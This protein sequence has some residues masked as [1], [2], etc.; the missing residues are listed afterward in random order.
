M[1]HKIKLFRKISKIKLSVLSK[2]ILVFVSLV[3]LIVI[4]QLIFNLFLAKEIYKSYKEGEM[5][6]CFYEIKENYDGSIASITEVIASYEFTESL[7]VVVTNDTD[8]IYVSNDKR[9]ETKT[10]LSSADLGGVSPEEYMQVPLP[11]LQGAGEDMSVLRLLGTFIFEE[12][13]LFVNITMP[14]ASIESSVQIFTEFGLAISLFVLIL[15]CI[16]FVIFSKQVTRPI[17]EIEKI[18]SKFAKLDF[19]QKANEN[20]SSLELASLAKSINTMSNRLEKNIAE[21]N[22]AN[23]QLMLDIDYQKQVEVMRREFVANVSHEMKTPLAM[24]QLYASNLQSNIEGID[25]DYYCETIIEESERLSEMVSSM[26]DISAVESGLSKMQMKNISLSQLTSNLITKM[27][28]LLESFQVSTEFTEDIC[29][30]GDSKYLEQAMKNYIMNAI[31]HTKEEGEI[32][33]SLT[34]AE[35][36]ATFEV[37][38]EGDLINPKDMPA[39]WDSFYRADKAR[40]RSGKNIGLGLYIVKTIIQNH[41]GKYKVANGEGGVSFAFQ[42]L[43]IN[44]ESSQQYHMDRLQ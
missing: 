2:M 25:R 21:L 6:E 34:R 29:V 5:E 31:S 36:V 23:E 11:N 9:Q 40:S 33:I 4:L 30:V 37:F 13:N 20:N 7:L 17:K 39:L 44:D 18:S 10:P 43:I 3:S 28:P 41:G 35:N 26:L 1:K 16:V 14:V 22:L 27:G 38:N 42:L 19:T 15:G 12:E 8:V 24:L 32:K